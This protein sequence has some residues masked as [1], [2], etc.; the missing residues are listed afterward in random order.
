MYLNLNEKIFS[1]FHRLIEKNYHLRRLSKT[2][3]DITASNNPVIFD[4][5]ANEGES[6]DFFLNLFANSTIYSFEPEMNSY[7][8]LIKKYGENKTINLFN[9]AFGDKKE[10]L[11]LKINVKSSTSTFSKINTQSKYYNLKSL[12]L[13]PKRNNIF[14]GEEEVQ[15][16]KIDNFF[17]QKKIKTIHILKIDTEGFELNVIEGAKETLQK[18]KI[19][20]IEFQ[21]NDMYLNYDS[22]KIEDFLIINNFALVKSLKFPF[23]QYEDRVYINKKY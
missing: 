11:K 5:G 18:T 3:K 19:I 6:I 20:I 13:N 15:V 21:L 7:Q 22:N 10:K 8:K 16:E 9:L 1:F 17:S 4:I 14:L 23:M 2:L 12:I